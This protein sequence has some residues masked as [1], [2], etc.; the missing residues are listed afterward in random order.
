M[1]ETLPIVLAA[2]LL[3]A[4]AF[5]PALA[6]G[7]GAAWTVGECLEFGAL[8]LRNPNPGSVL[9]PPRMKGLCDPSGLHTDDQNGHQACLE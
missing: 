1:H 8:F 9:W 7:L 3:L 6:A 5:S 4:E 2:E